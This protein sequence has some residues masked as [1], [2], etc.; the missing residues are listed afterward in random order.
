MK[1]FTLEF[2]LSMLAYYLGKLGAVS[3]QKA[4]HEFYRSHSEIEVIEKIIYIKN[5]IIREYGR[6]K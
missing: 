3:N 1:P 6:Q 5:R 2:W 4:I